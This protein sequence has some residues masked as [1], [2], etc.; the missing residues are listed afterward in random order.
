MNE[1]MTLAP[2]AFC[3]IAEPS[4]IVLLVIFNIGI[5]AAYFIIPA[6]ILF[7]LKLRPITLTY[8]FAVFIFGCGMTHVMQVV[9]MYFGGMSYWVEAACCGLTFIA[10][11]CTAIILAVQGPRIMAIQITP[12]D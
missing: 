8:L 11:A 3:L 7:Y 5:A 12:R 4:L 10:S 1:M 6:A 2:H 9:T